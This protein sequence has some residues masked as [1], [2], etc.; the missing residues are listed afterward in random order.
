LLFFTLGL[1]SKPMLVTLPFVMLLLD[2]W[3][4]GRFTIRDLRF[5]IWDLL[6]EK[7]PFFVL[8]T[9]SCIVT[10]LVQQKG[11]AVAALSGLP[12]G[13]RA[14]NALVSYARYLGKTFW[15]QD[16]AVLCPFP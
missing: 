14:A 11:G 13:A 12:V 6:R 4:L 9:A 3:P 1:M 2:Y 15:P 10:F 5:T 7:F 8:S 16:L